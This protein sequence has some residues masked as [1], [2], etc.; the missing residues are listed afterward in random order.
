MRRDS[1]ESAELPVVR[2]R[3]MTGILWTVVDPTFCLSRAPECIAIRRDM[4]K[5]S[6]T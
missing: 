6:D 5:K 3:E 4:T 1:A 2:A